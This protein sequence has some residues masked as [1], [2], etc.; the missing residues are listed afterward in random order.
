MK[1]GKWKFSL[2]FTFNFKK[3]VYPHKDYV[4]F[5]WWIV[6]FIKIKKFRDKNDRTHSI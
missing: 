1:L 2:E 4:I 6:G 3:G 5:D